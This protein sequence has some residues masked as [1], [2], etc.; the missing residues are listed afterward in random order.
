MYLI[1]H[2]WTK[3]N[4][5]DKCKIHSFFSLFFFSF[6]FFFLQECKKI[7]FLHCGL[8]NQIT[9]KYSNVYMVQSIKLKFGTYIIG[10]RP[11]NHIDFGN[12]QDAQCFFYSSTKN[13]HTLCLWNHIIISVSVSERY[14]LL[15]SNLVRVLEVLILHIASTL[16][17]LILIVSL[18]GLKKYSYL[19]QNTE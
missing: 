10:Q 14:T 17:N 12:L 7:F 8:W 2:H 16:V 3:V 19:L 1:G 11:A 6:F 13:S 5:A 9:K 18:E 15:S 4:G